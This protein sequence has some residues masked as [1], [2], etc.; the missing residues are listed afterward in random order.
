VTPVAWQGSGDV[1]SLC[2]ANAFL[3]ADPERGE[4]PK[5]D[6]ISILMK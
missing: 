1:P 6:L 2:R 3:I 4:Y 5:G